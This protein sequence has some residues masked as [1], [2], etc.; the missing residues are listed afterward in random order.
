MPMPSRTPVQRTDSN[1]EKGQ[2]A[3]FGGAVFQPSLP[4]QYEPARPAHFEVE[5]ICLTRGSIA[6]RERQ[7]FVERICAVYPEAP[8]EMRLDTPHNQL[9][10]NGRDPLALH[11]T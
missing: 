4:Q 1:R 5:R 7:R 8:V 2:R 11:Q 3:L 6:T 9:R 10:L